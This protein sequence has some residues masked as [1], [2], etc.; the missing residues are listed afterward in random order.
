MKSVP[1]PIIG[2]VMLAATIIFSPVI[3]GH[4]V[5]SALLREFKGS[6]D[7]QR[8]EFPKDEAGSRTA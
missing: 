6:S 1:K 4:I 7:N 2:I 3:V 5:F 8:M